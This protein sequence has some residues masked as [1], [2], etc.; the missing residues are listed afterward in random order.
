MDIQ[1]SRTHQTTYN[2]I[3]QHPAARNLQWHDVRSMLNSISE[4]EE[5]HNGN[6]RFTVPSDQTVADGT[7]LLVV[8]DHREAR[9][10]QT[11]LHGSVPERVVMHSNAKI[12]KWRSI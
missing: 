6:L 5:E 2:A 8:I 7:H 11:E 3:F 4:V 1:M 10:Y 9:I 12:R